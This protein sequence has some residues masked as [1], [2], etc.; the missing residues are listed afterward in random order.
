M[1]Q[2]CCFVRYLIDVEGMRPDDAIECK[3]E[4][5]HYFSLFIKVEGGNVDVFLK[6]WKKEM[7]VIHLL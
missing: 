2:L 3:Y 6:F 7:F 5:C 4:C 1:T